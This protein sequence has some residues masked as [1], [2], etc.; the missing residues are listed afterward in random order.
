M[1]YQNTTAEIRPE[2]NSVLEEALA[3][4][5][6]LIGLDIFPVFQV[7]RRTGQYRKLTLAAS[8]LLKAGDT[9]RAPK[10][11]YPEVDWTW[12]LDSYATYDRGLTQKI[13]DSISNDVAHAFDLESQAAKQ[14]LRRVR[15]S[16]EQRVSAATFNTSNFDSANSTVAYTAAN[17]AT[18]DFIEDVKIRLNA[19]RARGEYPN[20]MVI[21]RGVWD[22]VRKADLTAK[23]FFGSLGGGKNVTLDM[24]MGE[25]MLQSIKIADAVVD[26]ADKGQTPSVS[27]IW[28]NTHVWIGDVKGGDFG[29]GG[30]GRTLVWSGDTGGS[31]FVSET[32]RDENIRSDV[33]RVRSNMDEKVVSSKAGTLI[34]TQYA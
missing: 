27:Y 14:L 28:A 24:L 12:E 11:A 32:Y 6:F 9:K 33:L 13:D 26:T 19:L 25:F 16:H 15:L 29:G 17:L 5:N 7:D 22:R 1:A 31:T 20:T 30:A 2:L 4:D 21:P 23:F 10:T 34:V 8:E 18:I 3:V